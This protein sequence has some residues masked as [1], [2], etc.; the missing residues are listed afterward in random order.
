M[1]ADG[2]AE[3][4]PGMA[5]VSYELETKVPPEQVLEAARDFTPRRLELWSGIDPSRY[6]LHD[7]GEGWAEVT[8]G[9]A[10]FGGI[11]ARER[12]TWSGNTVAATVQESNVFRPGG[13][14]Q[15]TVEPNGDGGS[16]IRVSVH[17]Q[18]GSLR[19]RLLGAVVQVMGTR[20]LPASFAKTLARLEAKA[21]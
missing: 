7:S 11:W 2:R 17:R 10:V 19:G 3:Q 9:S 4:D 8:E 14:W 13:T 16:L 1:R 5:K 12:Y 6:E 20:V 21:G 15:L 18:A